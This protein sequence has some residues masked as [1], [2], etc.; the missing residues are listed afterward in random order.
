MFYGFTKR[1]LIIFRL[2][3]LILWPTFIIWLKEMDQDK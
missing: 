3:R 1:I 2:V